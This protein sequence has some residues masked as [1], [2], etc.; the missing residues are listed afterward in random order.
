[1]LSR[2]LRALALRCPNCGQPGVLRSWTR[3]VDRC[4]RCDHRY[5]RHEG[6]WLGAV[7]INTGVTI[8]VF[9]GVLV[10]GTAATWPDPP[11]TAISVATVATTLIFPV[12]FYPWSK[13]LWVALEISLHSPEH[14]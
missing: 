1:M 14:D 5:Q 12:L 6:Y 9:A 3:L 4:P 2:L 8:A 7:A 11:W 10:V 13:T